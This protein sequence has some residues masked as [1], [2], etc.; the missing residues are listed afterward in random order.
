MRSS[1]GQVLLRALVADHD[2]A[3]TP[4]E[5]QVQPGPVLV[6]RPATP[7]CGRRGA[8]RSPASWPAASGRR[9]RASA[10]WPTPRSSWPCPPLPYPATIEVHQ[11][12]DDRASVAFRGNRYSVPPGLTGTE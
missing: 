8:T 5:A 9:G 12:V 1:R 2:G 11:A 10:N 7:A 4:S 6:E 3:I